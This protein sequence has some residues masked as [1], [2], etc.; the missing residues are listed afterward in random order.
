M[1]KSSNPAPI[2]MIKILDCC[3]R[4]KCWAY[5]GDTP[6]KAGSGLGTRQFHE[7]DWELQYK[8]QTLS[9]NCLELVNRGIPLCSRQNILCSVEGENLGKGKFH[10]TDHLWGQGPLT[11]PHFSD[12]M[13]ASLHTNP[14]TQ[15]HTA[16][17]GL[18]SITEKVDIIVTSPSV[19]DTSQLT[20]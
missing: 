5:S 13:P 7:H 9:A 2:W 14:Y 19:V 4:W 18:L 6:W 1:D 3:H 16:H 20:L 10:M 17:T 8:L 11:S 15:Y 12:G